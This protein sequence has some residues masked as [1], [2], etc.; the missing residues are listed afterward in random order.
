MIV[1]SD[2][3]YIDTK[4]IKQGKKELKVEFL[5]LA[6]WIKETFGV[7]PLNIIYDTIPVIGNQPRLEIVFEFKKCADLFRD[8]NI[9]VNFDS[10]KQEAIARQFKNLHSQDYDTNK[11]F[12][13][14]SA[15]EPVAKEEANGNIKNEEIQALKKQ[16]DR[17]DLWE[18]SRAFSGA[19]FFLYTDKQAKDANKNG[20]KKEW[21]EIYFNVL[22]KYDEFGYFNKESFSVSV[23]SKENFDINY[24]GSWFNYYR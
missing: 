11:L 6:D 15:F 19:T 22:K 9:S 13:I 16:I 5:P 1:S 21:S 3:E 18:I 20:S 10:K 2:K 23:D 24:K 4:L 12:A 14:F 7:M 8:K 17:K